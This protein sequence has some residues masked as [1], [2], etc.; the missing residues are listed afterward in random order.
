[1][2]NVAHLDERI[3]KCLSIL[4]DNP[5]SQ[6]FAA[7][8]EA[9]RKRGDFGRA[10]AV[11]KGGLKHNPDY[12]PAH[13]VMARIYLHQGMLDEALAAIERA[14]KIS[15]PTRATDLVGAEVH[16]ARHDADA[17]RTVIDRLRA[18]D[19]HNPAVQV[20]IEN[21]RALKRDGGVAPPPPEVPNIDEA[22]PHITAAA[23]SPG[24][25]LTWP[26]WAE[27]LSREPAMRQVFV[28]GSSDGAVSARPMIAGAPDLSDANPPAAVCAAM[29]DQVDAAVRRA[30]GGTLEEIRVEFASGELW[31]R[32]WRECL[33][34]FAAARAL[35]FGAARQKAMDGAQQ[36]PVDSDH[37]IAITSQG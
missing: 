29:F 20:L 1:M 23:A 32:R 26:E 16:L 36:I 12:A 17:A 35:P 8:A 11:C 27:S 14:E 3:E 13:L 22:E 4:A 30:R 7:L 10:F 2:L 37:R 5:R 18:V 28:L 9:Y 24:G 21:L 33:M 25:P 19:R 31:C 34:G 15:G 6:V